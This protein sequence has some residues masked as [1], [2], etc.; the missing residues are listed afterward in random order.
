MKLAA[1]CLVAVI[2]SI[3][4]QSIAMA[5]E[6]WYEKYDTDHDHH[7]S[8]NEFRDANLSYYKLHK[9]EKRLEDAQMRTEFDKMAIGHPGYVD[10][11]TVK[12]YH[13]W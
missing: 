10:V 4:A 3:C 2:A 9:D 7:W 11:E 13:H 1:S 5:D 6:V 12:T 8:Y